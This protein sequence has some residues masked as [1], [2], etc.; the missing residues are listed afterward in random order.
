MDRTIHVREDKRYASPYDGIN[1]VVN[2]TDVMREKRKLLKSSIWFA[3][4]V[5]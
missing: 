1:G 4:K 2:G 3:G 5:P